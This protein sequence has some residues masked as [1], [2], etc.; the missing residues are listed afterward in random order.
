MHQRAD[1]IMDWKIYGSSLELKIAL[2]FKIYSPFHTTNV[3][4]VRISNTKILKIC[5][6][7]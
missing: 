1:E 7:E 4:N 2:Q 6:S 3:C 5:L